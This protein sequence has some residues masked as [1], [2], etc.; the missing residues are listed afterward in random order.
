MT[1]KSCKKVTL[2]YFLMCPLVLKL[3]MN[4][5]FFLPYNINTLPT[6]QA[7]NRY[8]EFGAKRAQIDVLLC[9]GLCMYVILQTR[10]KFL[11]STKE[12]VALSKEKLQRKFT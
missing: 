9:M 6:R 11:L 5:E 2:N 12:F 10:D 4:T 7:E 1:W 8:L 3:V